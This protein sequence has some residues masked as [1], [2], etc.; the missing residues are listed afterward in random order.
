MTTLS[1]TELKKNAHQSQSFFDEWLSK[2]VSSLRFIN[3]LGTMPEPGM[4]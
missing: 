3:K 4:D 2:L 1:I